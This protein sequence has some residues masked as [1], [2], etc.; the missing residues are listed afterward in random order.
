M[1]ELAKQAVSILESI[2][3][4]LMSRQINTDIHV[5]PTPWLFSSTDNTL[6]L[7]EAINQTNERYY[8]NLGEYLPPQS[9]EYSE[10][11]DSILRANV[12]YVSIIR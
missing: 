2:N 6:S 11:A 9:D 5:F 3:P 8:Q 12:N 1:H 4:E 10:A 7:Q